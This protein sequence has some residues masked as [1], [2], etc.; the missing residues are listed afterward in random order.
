MRIG[1]LGKMGSG[2]TTAAKLLY[3][4]MGYRKESLAGPL[5]E[6]AELR[7][8]GVTGSTLVG[9]LYEYALDLLPDPAYSMAI[10]N[11]THPRTGVP[12]ETTPV[13]MLVKLWLEDLHEAEDMRELYQRIGT[14]SGRFIK[15]GIW[16]DH[17]AR[18]LRDG[19]CVIDDIRFVNEGD[20]LAKLGF[21]KVKI[22]C[23]EEKRQEFLR[24]R[25]GDFQEKRQGHASETEL[26]QIRPDVLIHNISDK[27]FLYDSVVEVVHRFR[28]REFYPGQ[29]MVQYA[30]VPKIPREIA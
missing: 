26:D 24:E 30:P 10:I 1:F 6:I 3:S 7:N 11:F 17:F 8:E 12:V 2:K 20:A 25:D 5:K 13:Q 22:T 23:P 18:N 21:L 29:R 19:D 14:D 4:S 9:T 16:I 15:P 27:K 28:Y